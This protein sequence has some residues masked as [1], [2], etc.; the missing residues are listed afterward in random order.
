MLKID[1]ETTAEW[2]CET[3][4]E[5]SA[6]A[7]GNENVPVVATPS[8]IGF[9]EIACERAIRPF[10]E[11]GEVSVAIAVNVDHVASAPVGSRIVAQGKVAAVVKNRVVFDVTAS[12]DERVIM[13]G[14]HSRA[15]VD[16][17]RFLAQHGETY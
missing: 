3:T 8:V 10:Y 14:T 1:P 12:D 17:E 7:F 6:E 13:Q 4:A 2:E 5:H 11:E 9:I 16:L 15:I